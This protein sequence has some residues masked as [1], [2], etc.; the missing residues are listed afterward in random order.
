M[1]AVRSLAT[2]IDTGLRQKAGWLDSWVFDNKHA[3]RGIAMCRIIIGLVVFTLLFSNYPQRSI[4]FGPG[5]IWAETARETSTFPEI[6]L[7]SGASIEVFTLGYL[8]V[9]VSALAFTLGWH[10]RLAG[11]ITLFGFIAVIGQNPVL[12]GQGDNIVRLTLLWLVLMHSSAH[13]SLDERRRATKPG[14]G[15]LDAEGKPVSAL[16]SGWNS[17]PILPPTFTNGVHNVAL[18]GISF[19]I[20]VIY[21]AAGMYKIQPDL[22]ENGTALYYTLQL[23]DSRP[24]GALSSLLTGSGALIGLA[25]Y[26]IV[27]TQLFLVPL[28]LNKFTKPPM[29]T[30]AVSIH[31]LTALFMARP[32]SSF[33]MIALLAIFISDRTYRRTSRWSK[34]VFA[35]VG[36]WLCM[37]YHDLRDIIDWV[38]ERVDNLWFKIMDQVDKIRYR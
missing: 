21:I 26:T 13:W 19:Q 10:T 34:V 25:T 31:L 29:L 28:L 20:A 24:F 36:D 8:L 9:M 6:G 30:L 17:H 23:P 38:R 14:L 16:R 4:V 1:T 37:R 33:A 22:W 3:L 11:V 2:A 12:G 7:L 27:F 35:P 32:W 15:D 5:S 18:A